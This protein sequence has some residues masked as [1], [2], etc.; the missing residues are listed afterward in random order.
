MNGNVNLHVL[1]REFT[2]VTVG[3]MKC[4]VTLNEPPIMITK[5]QLHHFQMPF[6]FQKVQLRF[7]VKISES[8]KIIFAS[9][10]NANAVSKLLMKYFEGATLIAQCVSC[11][12]TR[13]AVQKSKCAQ[14]DWRLEVISASCKAEY[15]RNRTG[16]WC[17]YSCKR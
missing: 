14:L 8:S 6:P 11:N 4:T 5:L 2:P 15:C 12:N 1:R 10:S 13:G 7:F 16:H 3:F 17:V 9:F